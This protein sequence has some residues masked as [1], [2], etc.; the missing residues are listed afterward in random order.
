MF[1]ESSLP[2]I[3]PRYLV[4]DIDTL[5]DWTRAELMYQAYLNDITH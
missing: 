4:Q 2:V 3:L 1:S 5:E